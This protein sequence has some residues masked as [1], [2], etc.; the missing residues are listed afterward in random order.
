MIETLSKTIGDTFNLLVKAFRLSSIF[1]ALCFVLINMYLL[2]AY[3]FNQDPRSFLQETDL[4]SN[5]RVLVLTFILTALISY[6]LNYLNFPLLY[7]AE[8]YPFAGS[9][10]FRFFRD[11]QI[12]YKE[13]L[14]Q[15]A[16]DPPLPELEKMILEERLSDYF[17]PR[18]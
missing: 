18:N 3:P 9:W 15:K 4:L 17:P 12:A 1:P 2:M 7:L 10:W 11:W 5:P 8:G 16:E 6:I 14:R 13:H